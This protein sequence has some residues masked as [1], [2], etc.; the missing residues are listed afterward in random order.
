MLAMHHSP[1]SR[2]ITSSYVPHP[3]TLVLLHCQLC[4]FN[5]W[6]ADTPRPPSGPLLQVQYS[7][8]IARELYRWGIS[9]VAKSSLLD[10]EA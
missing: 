6:C 2:A 3:E 8:S 7:R 10:F 4:G 5:S 9:W 1:M